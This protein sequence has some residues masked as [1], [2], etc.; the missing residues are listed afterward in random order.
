MIKDTG[1]LQCPALKEKKPLRTYKRE[2]KHTCYAQI[3]STNTNTNNYAPKLNNETI[4][5]NV[6]TM[7]FCL[8]SAHMMNAAQPGS[9]QQHLDYMTTSNKLPR[10][11]GPEN[12][13]S[14]DIIQAVLGNT[15]PKTQ[16]I[17]SQ[18]N[19]KDEEEEHT[20]TNNISEESTDTEETLEETPDITVTMEDTRSPEDNIQ[21]THSTPK[22]TKN[23]N[24]TPKDTYHNKNTQQTKPKPNTQH[25]QQQNLLQNQITHEQTKEPRDPRLRHRQH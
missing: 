16:P 8:Y 15:I 17:P 9:F 4:T 2:H 14:K 5:D 6:A 3:T 20:P 11:I 12:P 13:P 18:S 7:L 10:L 1:H 19:H 23:K 21:I 24:K 25:H 22:N